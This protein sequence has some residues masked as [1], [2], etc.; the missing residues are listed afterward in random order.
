MKNTLKFALVAALAV[1]L[2]LVMVIAVLL[3]RQSEPPRPS[4]APTNEAT[5]PTQSTENLT[6][7][8]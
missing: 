5:F 4:D 8:G 7:W 2:I 3:E 1:I 6:P